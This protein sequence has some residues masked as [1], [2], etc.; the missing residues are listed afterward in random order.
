MENKNVLKKLKSF[1]AQLD[2]KQ[3]SRKELETSKPLLESDLESIKEILKISHDE[4][5]SEIRTREEIEASK[6][7]VKNSLSPILV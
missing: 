1:L 6:A 5:E 7:A 4:L 3:N 2:S